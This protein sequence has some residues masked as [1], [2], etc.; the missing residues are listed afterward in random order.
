MLC[1]GFLRITK[2]SFKLIKEIK[3][4]IHEDNDIKAG[5]LEDICTSNEI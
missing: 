4:H 3:L 1:T 2:N 5:I